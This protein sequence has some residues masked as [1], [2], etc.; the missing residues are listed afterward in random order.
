MPIAPI[1][2]K[3]RKR[4]WLDLTV[5]MGLGVSFGYAFWYGVHLK[6]VQRHEEYYLKLERRRQLEA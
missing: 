5:A 4:F 6:H 1:T 3:L 2:G